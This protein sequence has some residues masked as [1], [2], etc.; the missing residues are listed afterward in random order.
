MDQSGSHPLRF[1]V[2]EFDPRAGELRK[3]GMKLK[4]HGQPIEILALL[5][6]HPGEVVTREELQRKLWP[7]DTFVDF[8]HS[9]NAAVKRLRDALDDSA[10]SPRYIETLSRRGYRFIGRLDS[11][12]SAPIRS[13]AILPFA[14]LSGDPGQEYF[15]DGMTDAL[16]TELGKISALRVISRQSMMQYK[17][18]KKSVPQIACELNVEAVLEGSV[19][20]AGDCVRISVQLIQ[21]A[22]ERHLWA[23][24]CDRELRDVLALHSEMA[25][26]VAGE[27][28]AKLTPQ[29]QAQLTSTRSVNPEAYQ[30]YLQGRYFLVSIG[31]EDFFRK[32]ARYLEDSVVKDPNYAPAY[33]ALAFT[34]AKLAFYG[35]DAPRIGYPK[36]TT[37]V[38]KALELDENLGEGHTVL[39]HIKL[40][41]DWDWSGAEKEHRRALELSPNSADAHS[42]YGFYLAVMGRSDEGIA[43]I[44]KALELDPVPA[45]RT[46]HMGWCNLMARRY[47]DAL[48]HLKKALELNPVYP[49]A[50]SLLAWTYART[51]MPAEAN[52]EYENAR[53]FVP[54]GK[55]QL[56][57]A[58]LVPIY[59]LRGRCDEGLKLADWWIQESTRRHV[60]SYAVA[61]LYAQLGEKER[62][63]YWLERA[64]AQH[65]GFMPGLKAEPFVDSLRSDPRFQDLL[66]RMNFPP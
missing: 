45:Q 12:E 40:F 13:L 29:E 64:F 4:L 11:L 54:A 46:S 20:R 57:D 14:N 16:I 37:T 66:R 24:S 34:Y 63:L 62:A 42:E 25:R 49:P 41:F 61:A 2:F 65:S 26:A 60:N 47:D 36:A 22:P 56:L 15:A 5:L 59:V 35:Y 44:Q 30:L 3:Q 52:A 58:W 27:V 31:S 48:V 43:Q 1:G 33:S 38:M 17:G 8:E 50:H 55:D 19:L 53:R 18:T 28:R 21:A 23:Q 10:D 51:G 32:A 6:E 9:L 39:G 7:A